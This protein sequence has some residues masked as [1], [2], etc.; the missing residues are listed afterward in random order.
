LVEKLADVGSI[1]V[2]PPSTNDRV[3]LLNERM[4]TQRGL[5]SCSFPNLILEMLD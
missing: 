4:R 3:Q 1:V 2:V 5:S